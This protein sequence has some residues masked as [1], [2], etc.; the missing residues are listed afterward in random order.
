MTW[1]PY[2]KKSEGDQPHNRK[3][4]TTGPEVSPPFSGQDPGT[5][6]GDARGERG[7]VAINIT[8]VS[9]IKLELHAT[10]A[11]AESH[12]AA[13]QVALVRPGG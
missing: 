13:M 7:K 8:L 2:Q 12:I 1:S 10:T 6:K 4:R 9:D 3:L 5:V 11:L